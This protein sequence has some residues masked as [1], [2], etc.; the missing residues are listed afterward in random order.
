[1]TPERIPEAMEAGAVMVASGF[2][3][4]LKGLPEDVGVEGMAEAISTY[5]DAARRARE[6]CWPEMAVAAG[7]DR[8]VWLDALP[9]Y[10]PW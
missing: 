3:V 2:D 8:Q 7:A 4:M 6:A 10:H 9:H 1:M 5:L